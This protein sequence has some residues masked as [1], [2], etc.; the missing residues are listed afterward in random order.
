MDPPPFKGKK[1]KNGRTYVHS[2][3]G[4]RPG[5]V[6]S[7]TPRHAKATYERNSGCRPQ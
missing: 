6:R 4:W 5:C 1:P 2:E 3:S 7:Q